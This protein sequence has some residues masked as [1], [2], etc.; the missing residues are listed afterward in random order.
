MTSTIEVALF[1]A[2]IGMAGIFVFMAVFYLLILAL[3]KYLPH[4]EKMEEE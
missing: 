4:E 1:I 2:G 3:D